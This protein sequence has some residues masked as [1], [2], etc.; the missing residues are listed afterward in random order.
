[1]LLA[2]IISVS[3]SQAGGLKVFGPEFCGPYT[4]G[5]CINFHYNDLANK[6]TW[7]GKYKYPKGKD[8][9]DTC[10]KAADG[11][12]GSAAYCSMRFHYAEQTPKVRREMCSTFVKQ[13]YWNV[14]S[15]YS[16]GLY[17]IVWD[18]D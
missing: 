2:L 10:W 7:L 17:L 16:Y 9:W 3:M 15:Q 11:S 18:C 6:K 4:A 14:A 8:A 1:M 13:E 12:D 5:S